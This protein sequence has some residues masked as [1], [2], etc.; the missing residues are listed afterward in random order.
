MISSVV[1][2]SVMIASITT[3]ELVLKDFAMESDVKKILHSAHCMAQNLAVNLAS[4]TSKDN[5]MSSIVN[6]LREKL[7][8]NPD[9]SYFYRFNF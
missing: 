8:P 5:L 6:N 1:D 2:R 4:V 9:V 7:I 3:K